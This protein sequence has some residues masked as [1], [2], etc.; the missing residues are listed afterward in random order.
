[1]ESVL[2]RQHARVTS[3][4]PRSISVEGIGTR[5][6]GNNG[7]GAIHIEVREI[8]DE[9][10]VGE[11]RGVDRVKGTGK[12]GPV[13]NVKGVVYQGGEIIVPEDVQG[14]C[15]GQGAVNGENIVVFS[16]FFSAQF[17]G[18]G[19]ICQLGIIPG[20][21]E[22]SR[23]SAWGQGATDIDQVSSDAERLQSAADE[24]KCSVGGVKM[25]RGDG[26]AR[27]QTYNAISSR[28]CSRPSDSE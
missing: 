2:R 23:R 10:V 17:H 18:Q 26:A 25:R 11:F 28:P 9:G 27:I 13:E 24:G 19:G 1:M 4:E 22:P 7:D 8:P 20:N 5:A 21:R 3:P 6:G 12:N 16:C 15:Q 14:T